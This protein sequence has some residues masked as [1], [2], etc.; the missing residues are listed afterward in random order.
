MCLF[1]VLSNYTNEEI[2]VQIWQYRDWVEES[3]EP[4]YFSVYTGPIKTIP[5]FILR[6]TFNAMFIDEDDKHLLHL[7][8][9]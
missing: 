3:S 9:E 7:A 2:I 8:V 4:Q 5:Y 1:D 6:L